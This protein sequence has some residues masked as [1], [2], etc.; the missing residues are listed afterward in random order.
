MGTTYCEVLWAYLGT[1]QME[2]SE[3]KIFLRMRQ[4]A[5]RTVIL[6]GHGSDRLEPTVI[7]SL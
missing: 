4:D 2:F 3:E 5:V 6:E 1:D 7:I